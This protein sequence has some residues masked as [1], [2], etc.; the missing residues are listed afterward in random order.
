MV[1]L[2][3]Q[4]PIFTIRCKGLLGF[5]LGGGG[6]IANTIPCLH[7]TCYTYIYIQCLHRNN[8]GLKPTLA[9]SPTEKKGEF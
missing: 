4:N 7:S 3:Y 8:E 6:E 5:F 2:I 1:A 9:L